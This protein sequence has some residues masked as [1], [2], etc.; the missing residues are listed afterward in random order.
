[1]TLLEL[2]DNYYF[3]DS[4]L[5][6]IE[7]KNNDLKLHCGFCNF[8]QKNYEKGNNTNSDIIVVFHN[9]SY[10]IEGDLEFDAGFLSQK[11]QDG[12]I[13]FFLESGNGKF[14]SLIICAEA[15]EVITLN[16]YNL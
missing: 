16:T 15:V 1:M 11:L 13:H 8:L 4:V 5:E 14:G 2:N 3:H 6:R 10:E 7:Y 12:S 9:A